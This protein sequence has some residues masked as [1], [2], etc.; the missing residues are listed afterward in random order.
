MNRPILDSIR[1]AFRLQHLVDIEIKDDRIVGTYPLS[2]DVEKESMPRVQFLF[3]T[4]ELDVTG[5][6][7]AS[8]KSVLH[9]RIDYIRKR[10]EAAE[11]LSA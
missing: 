6:V 8:V 3:D 2:G 10:A 7:P 4:A 1:Q 11:R 9:S 5:P